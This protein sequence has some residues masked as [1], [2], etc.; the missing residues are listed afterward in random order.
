MLTLKNAM[1]YNRWDNSV[2]RLAG[3]IKKPVLA[4]L[5]ELDHIQA[6]F[7]SRQL[8][9]LN[10]PEPPDSPVGDLLPSSSLVSLLQPSAQGVSD[11][12]SA[13][14]DYYVERTPSPAS[15]FPSTQP[16]SL[17]P[18][19][20]SSAP[21][22][23]PAPIILKKSHK[24]APR[25][26]RV[27][28]SPGFKAFIPPLARSTR[29][30]R[31]SLG[32]AGGLDAPLV[33]ASSSSQLGSTEPALNRRPSTR[34]RLSLAAAQPLPQPQPNLLQSTE[35]Q[36]PPPDSIDSPITPLHSDAD[37]RHSSLAPCQPSPPPKLP[38]PP[39]R[40]PTS[41]L[42]TAPSSHPTLSE[43]AASLSPPP[44]ETPESAPNALAITSAAPS[45]DKPSQKRKRKAT[46]APVPVIADL[47]PHDTFLQFETGWILPE[48]SRRGAAKAREHPTPR[49]NAPPAK[50]PRIRIKKSKSSPK[51]EQIVSYSLPLVHVRS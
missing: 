31:T 38:S 24:K 49:K 27:D 28:S 29:A 21:P 15:P 14:F 40:G 48:G 9:L 1:T 41:S 26:E 45:S 18:P 13:L 43:S 23:P 39:P 37:S 17:S 12:I 42:P 16:P 4:Y 19:A 36:P 2:H 30:S 33:A 3:R 32:G 22:A 20:S 25:L 50:K 34:V 35:Q 5:A 47:N 51:G 46:D 11:P 44:P 6:T 10:D 8:S 7:N